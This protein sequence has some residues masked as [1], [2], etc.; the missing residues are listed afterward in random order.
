M[1]SIPLQLFR[2]CTDSTRYDRF[3]WP[4]GGVFSV[5]SKRAFEILRVEEKKRV[6]GTKTTQASPTTLSCDTAILSAAERH[7]QEYIEPRRLPTSP[8]PCLPS[9]HT[10]NSHAVLRVFSAAVHFLTQ[11]PT[12]RPPSA[13]QHLHC[14]FELADEQPT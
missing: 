12:W 9:A 11:S 10:N 13:S 1:P 2:W 6:L 8:Y 3:R 5:C 4:R 14:F 7:G